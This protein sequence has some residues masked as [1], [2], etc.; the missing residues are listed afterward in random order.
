[1]GKNTYLL[2]LFT[3]ISLV[4]CA[5]VVGCASHPDDKAAV[6]QVLDQHKLASVEVSQDRHAGVITLRGVV[7]NAQSKAQAEQLVLQ[8]APGYTVKNQLQVQSSEIT[9]APLHAQPA[10][11][12]N[13]RNSGN[14]VMS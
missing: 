10:G 2:T 9:G 3:A 14:A 1:M 12:G 11:N 8:A 4:V 6:Y 7:A 5:A 13:L